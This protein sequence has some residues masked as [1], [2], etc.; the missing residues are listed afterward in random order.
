[1]GAR[2][3]ADNNWATDVLDKVLAGKEVAYVLRPA[4]GCIISFPT[5]DH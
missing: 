4:D 3:K 1:M 5:Q 2:A